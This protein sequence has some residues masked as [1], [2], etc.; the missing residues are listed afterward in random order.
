MAPWYV[1]FGAFVEVIFFIDL[2]LMFCTSYLNRKGKEE[3]HSQ[4]I[5]K[6]YMKSVRFLT[7][8]MAT[9]GNQYFS[10]IFPS[11]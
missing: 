3:F 2:L 5:A 6:S 1:R 7:D 8:T 9:L 10:S 11:I 4:A